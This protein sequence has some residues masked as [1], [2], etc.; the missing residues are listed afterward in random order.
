MDSDR[1]R[2]IQ[3][4]VGGQPARLVVQGVNHQADLQKYVG[5]SVGEIAMEDGKHP[6]EAMLDLSLMGDQSIFVRATIAGV[7]RVLSV[8]KMRNELSTRARRGS[9]L[10]TG[11]P[12]CRRHPARDR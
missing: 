4:G 9:R 7:L 10:G 2:A 12:T 8:L 3:A 5:R 11:S 1:L 6:I